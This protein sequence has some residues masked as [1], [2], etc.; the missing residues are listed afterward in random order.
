MLDFQDEGRVIIFVLY[1]LAGFIFTVGRICVFVFLFYLI[2]NRELFFG[3][4]DHILNKPVLCLYNK[5][6]IDAA[7]FILLNQETVL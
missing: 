7:Y 3:Q 1:R 4:L 2:R 6:V 5:D